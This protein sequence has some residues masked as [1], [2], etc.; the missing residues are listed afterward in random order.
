M[1]RYIVYKNICIYIHIYIYVFIRLVIMTLLFV[2]DHSLVSFCPRDATGH[3]NKSGVGMQ[4]GINSYHFHRNFQVG[5]TA[6]HFCSIA[7]RRIAQYNGFVLEDL[8]MSL[9]PQ[10]SISRVWEYFYFLSPNPLIIRWN[11]M[12]NNILYMI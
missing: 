9:V 2:W 6:V 7:R 1:R 3:E 5:A 4:L 11:A 10:R 8:V 12:I